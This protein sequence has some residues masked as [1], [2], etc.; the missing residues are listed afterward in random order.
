M[1]QNKLPFREDTASRLIRIAE[2]PRLSDSATWRNLPLSYRAL[3]ELAR[4]STN[5]FDEGVKSRLIYPEMRVS[6]AAA[7]ARTLIPVTA[8]P[9]EKAIAEEERG[10]LILSR[11]KYLY[12]VMRLPHMD[13][14]VELAEFMGTF[15]TPMIADDSCSE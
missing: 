14:A 12:C 3:S 13:R 10:D 8:D 11:Q 1:C 9:I 2:H 4:L 5:A 7:V 6:D 15:L